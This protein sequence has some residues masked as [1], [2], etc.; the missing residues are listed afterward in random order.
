[1]SPGIRVLLGA[2]RERR[3][4]NV[5]AAGCRPLPAGLAAVCAALLLAGCGPEGSTPLPTKQTTIDRVNKS[6]ERS[7]ED[8][9]E[10]RRAIDGTK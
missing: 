9:D 4:V 3:H 7:R 8:A 2:E 6:L 10:R 5:N 1:M